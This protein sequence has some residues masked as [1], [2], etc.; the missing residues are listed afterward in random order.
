MGHAT[1][2]I[3]VLA[4]VVFNTLPHPQSTR[5]KCCNGIVLALCNR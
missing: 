4:P 5:S 3:S 1:L 2:G